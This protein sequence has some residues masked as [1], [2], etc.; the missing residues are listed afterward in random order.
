MLKSL[1]PKERLSKPEGDSVALVRVVRASIRMGTAL[2]GIHRM[3][4]S[5][6]V[7][8]QTVSRI[9][10]K[11]CLDTGR[12]GEVPAHSEVSVGRTISRS[13]I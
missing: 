8:V 11:N 13:C 7:M 1:K 3:A 6:R 9:S 2:I 12:D 5:F 10:S 4:K